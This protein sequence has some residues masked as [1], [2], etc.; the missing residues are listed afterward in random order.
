MH[1]KF[2]CAVAMS[3]VLLS[4]C[5]PKPVAEP[6]AE[7]AADVVAEAAPPALTCDQTLSAQLPFSN[8]EV[9]DTVTVRSLAPAPLSATA[10]E[11]D[12]SEGGALCHNAV[13]VYTVHSGTTGGPLYTFATPLARMDVHAI[14]APLDLADVLQAIL[15]STEVVSTERAPALDSED[16]V[17]TSLTEADYTDLMARK[18]P[19]LCF[20]SSVHDLSCV[21][22]DPDRSGQGELMAVWSTY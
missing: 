8:P 16:P 22:S 1:L 6:A 12:M 19:L 4:A 3:S 20:K 2:L 13:V 17:T 18:L 10:L 21:F 14:A 5:Q 7:P 15:T 9:P 11:G